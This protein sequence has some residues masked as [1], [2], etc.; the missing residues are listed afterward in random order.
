MALGIFGTF[1]NPVGETGVRT[2]WG[3]RW[4]RVTVYKVVVSR[5]YL[6]IHNM[7]LAVA[8]RETIVIQAE[9]SGGVASAPLFPHD[10]GISSHLSA[11]AY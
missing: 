7:D 3:V 4:S 2:S 10:W 6:T 11:S 1:K 8:S 5:R 9:R